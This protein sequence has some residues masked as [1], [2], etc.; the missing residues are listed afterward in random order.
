MSSGRL[1]RAFLASCPIIA[2]TLEFAGLEEVGAAKVL[3]EQGWDLDAC[4][5]TVRALALDQDG[6]AT[7]ATAAKAQARLDAAQRG[8]DVVESLLPTS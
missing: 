3:V 1:R 8:A 5:S 7:M 2:L 4:V 6:L